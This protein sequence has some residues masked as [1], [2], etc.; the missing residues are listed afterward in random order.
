[1]SL[2]PAER[3]A[4]YRKRKAA[5][6]PSLRETNR[7]TPAEK[8][9]YIAKWMKAYHRRDDIQRAAKEA[10]QKTKVLVLTHYGDGICAC[11]ACGEART[12]CLSIDHIYG[13]GQEHRDKVPD[14]KR[15]G[16]YRWL[17]SRNYPI[18]YQTLC[19][20]C[21]WVKRAT[22]NETRKPCNKV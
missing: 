5:G 12:E 14:I 6:I 20:N 8:K 16:F 1:M 15:L 11:V 2:T 19:M 9:A 7:K 10:R 3:Q 17:I 18:G 13:G 21:Q 4:A 22:N